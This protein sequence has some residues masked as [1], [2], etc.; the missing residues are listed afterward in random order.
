MDSSDVAWFKRQPKHWNLTPEKFEQCLE[1]LENSCEHQVP[2]LDALLT[3]SFVQDLQ[4]NAIEAIFDHWLDKRLMGKQKLLFHVRKEANQKRSKL[5]KSDDPYVAFR[6]CQIKMHTRKNRAADQENYVRM[7]LGR[8]EMYN[9]LRGAMKLKQNA[10]KKLQVV[11]MKLAMFE[12]QTKSQNFIETHITFPYNFSIN[13]LSFQDYF[14]DFEDS[15]DSEEEICGD[16]SLE[17]EDKEDFIF[18][19]RKE[20]QYFSVRCL[21]RCFD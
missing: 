11:K 18:K 5:L 7:L 1:W 8:K 6:Q 20:C 4:F 14:V 21:S 12:E 13:E 17:I 10:L 15:E 3:Q 19:P 16:V 2:S 9:Y